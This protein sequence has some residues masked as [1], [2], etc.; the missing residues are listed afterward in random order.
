M[1]ND[2]YNKLDGKLDKL[3][4]KLDKLDSRVDNIDVTLGKQS[5][6]LEDHI[7]RSLANEKAVSVLKEELKPVFIHV[8]MMNILGKVCIAIISSGMVYTILKYL[9]R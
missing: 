6:I 7:R 2:D 4:N 5:V 8:S 1:N 3:D 9:F